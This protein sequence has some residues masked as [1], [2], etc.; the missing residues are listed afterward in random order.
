MAG[1][2]AAE[3]QFT[4]LSRYFNSTTIKG[5]ANVSLRCKSLYKT[6][7]YDTCL[8]TENLHIYLI[9]T[10]IKELQMFLTCMLTKQTA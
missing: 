9:L 3:S 5:R 7:N 1:D 2:H 8:Y 10:S 4:G 6:K